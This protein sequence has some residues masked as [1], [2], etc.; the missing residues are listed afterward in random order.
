MILL[1]R[2]LN[3]AAA[4]ILVVGPLVVGHP[5]VVFSPAPVGTVDLAVAVAAVA[6][7]KAFVQPQCP[8]PSSS[9]IL[10]LHSGHFPAG[11]G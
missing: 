8:G 9:P 11:L 6:V 2:I 3:P 7:Q 1:P 10:L 5:V 4:D